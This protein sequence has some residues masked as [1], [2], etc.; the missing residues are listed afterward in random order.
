MSKPS[1]SVS[2][3]SLN[4]STPL[5]GGPTPLE[6]ERYPLL[7][8]MQASNVPLTR[9]NYLEMDWP[10]GPPAWGAELEAEMPPSLREY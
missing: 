1:K 10:E 7:M 8:E 9:A 3:H 6:M 4:Q 5:R 2:Q